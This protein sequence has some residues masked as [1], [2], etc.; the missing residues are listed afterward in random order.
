MSHGDRVST[1]PECAPTPAIEA[2]SAMDTRIEHP[3]VTQARA[4]LQ[5][6][7]VKP[8]ISVN[9]FVCFLAT[10]S[11]LRD[12]QEAITQQEWKKAMDV[13]YQILEKKQNLASCPKEGGKKCDRCKVNIQDQETC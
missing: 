8:K 5:N 11:E 13:E 1:T 6:N 12:F 2:G 9:D 10:A 3:P 7:I 4:R